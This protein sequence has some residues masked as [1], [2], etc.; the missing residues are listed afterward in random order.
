[1]IIY[2]VTVK[3]E[4][5]IQKEWETWMRSVHIPDV[6]ATG[7][8]N[9]AQLRKLLYL[10]DDG[11]SYS[12]QYRCESMADLEAYQSQHAERLQAEH[13]TRFK[14]KYVAFRTLM[15]QLEEF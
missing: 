6:M 12:V 11:V 7:H 1:M 5:G 15:H 2:N 13:A 8:F 3:I 4:P 9:D 10:E 14:N